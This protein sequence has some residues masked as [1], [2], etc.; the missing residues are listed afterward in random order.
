MELKTLHTAEAES[1]EMVIPKYRFDEISKKYR[2]EKE[3]RL[4]LVQLL[5]E[6]QAQVQLL[7]EQIEEI[8]AGYTSALTTLRVKEIFVEGGI[9]KK[10]YENLIHKMHCSE[11]DMLAL[12]SAIVQLVREK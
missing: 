1:K 5:E 7:C 3:E 11:E 2:A 10:D 8:K 4:H 6:S 12:A 9:L